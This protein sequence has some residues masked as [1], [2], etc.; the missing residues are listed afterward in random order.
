MSTIEKLA[1]LNLVSKLTD[2]ISNFTGVN[3]KTL[4]EFVL[5]LHSQASDLDDLKTKLNGMGAEFPDG[6]I[7]NIDRIIK[8]M[9]PK[10]KVPKANNLKK[11][12]GTINDTVFKGL[13]LP[14]SDPIRTQK[15]MEEHDNL[16]DAKKMGYEKNLSKNRDHQ[17]NSIDRR[18]ARVDRSFDSSEKTQNIVYRER[19][20]RKRELPK[21]VSL[22]EIYDGIVTTVKQFGAFVSI[23]G[24]R[25]KTEGKINCDLCFFFLLY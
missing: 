4:A 24:V 23:E 5:D 20:K 6:F 12:G 22:G 16:A 19:E 8:Q 2:E 9:H 7:E 11:S 1:I 13:S 10:F 3:D 15:Y 21:T 25:E 14:D 17:T 18:K